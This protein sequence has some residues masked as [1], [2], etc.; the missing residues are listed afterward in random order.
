MWLLGWERSFGKVWNRSENT[1]HCLSVQTLSL[2]RAFIL[3][4]K[5]NGVL[6]W[7]LGFCAEG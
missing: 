3:S 1:Q 2:G 6:K 7:T 5:N 4:L